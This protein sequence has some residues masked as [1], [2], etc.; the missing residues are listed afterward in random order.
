MRKSC[1]DCI[2]LNFQVPNTHGYS[3]H[4]SFSDH[5]LV[6]IYHLPDT[7]HGPKLWRMLSDSLSCNLVVQQI[8]LIIDCFEK[9]NLITSW[10]NLKVKVQ[11]VIQQNTKFHQRQ[12][13][14]EIKGLHHTLKYINL[15]IFQG[16]NLESNRLWIQ[17]KIDQ[18]LNRS[19]LCDDTNDCDIDWVLHEGKM[20]KSF[21][22]LEDVSCPLSIK[23]LCTPQGLVQDSSQILPYLHNFYS[24]LYSN[25]D[26]KTD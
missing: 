19:W 18:L 17:S 6:G 23:E 4:V 2:Y 22:H 20:V 7:D 3:H 11:Q 14:Q 9:K 25:N 12:L 10:E 24:H 5:Y 15:R 8:Q 13:Q 16:E 26:C 1:L 21:L